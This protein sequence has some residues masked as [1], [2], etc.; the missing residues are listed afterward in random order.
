MGAHDG[1]PLQFEGARRSAGDHDVAGLLL[2]PA[3]GGDVVVAAVQN[4]QLAGAGLAGPVGA[5]RGE[6]VAR[7][8][9]EPVRDGGHQPVG[10]G[11]S[12]DVVADAVELDEDR[13]GRSAAAA[14]R[15]PA[16][17]GA[18]AA[19]V[20]EARESAAVGVVVA[21]G[22]RGGCRGGHGGHHGG[23][24]DRGLGVGGAAPVRGEPQGD[25]QQRAVEEEDQH[26][27]DE[28]GHDEQRPYQSRPDQR[29][30]QTERARAP[31]RRERDPGDAVTVVRLELE[32]RQH[33]GECQHREGRDGPHH[34]HSHEGAA[35]S[36]PSP[37]THAV[38]PHTSG[39]PCC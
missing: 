4:A 39:P 8:V 6:P 20:G 19:T 9:T 37:V 27:Q 24:D 14:V 22:E 38:P 18:T 3:E 12:E 21:D 35:G 17:A 16:R 32:V 10:G 29:G 34:D 11:L 5:P 30:E 23:D 7:P 36:A 31:G 33:R 28:G 25:Q 13:S 2:V 15:A 26:P 1:A